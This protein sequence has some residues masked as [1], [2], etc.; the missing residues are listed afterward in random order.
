MSNVSEFKSSK[1]MSASDMIASDGELGDYLFDRQVSK[2]REVIV[3][4]QRQMP[5]TEK[6]VRD[7]GS[8]SVSFSSLLV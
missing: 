4:F 6:V 1:G 2:V 8:M 3:L 5:G 7:L